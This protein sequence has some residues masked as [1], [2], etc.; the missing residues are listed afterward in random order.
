MCTS[1]GRE[2]REGERENPSR[3]HVISAEPYLGLE[4]TDREI[5]T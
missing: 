3:F 1:G 4:L 2:E 5:M